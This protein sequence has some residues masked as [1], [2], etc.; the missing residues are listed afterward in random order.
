MCGLLDGGL[1]RHRMD[2]HHRCCADVT[3][4]GSW[5]SI[6]FV[7]FFRI[8]QVSATMMIHFLIL[9]LFTL[10][11]MSFFPLPQKCDIDVVVGYWWRWYHWCRLICRSHCD[12]RIAGKY[13]AS[14]VECANDWRCRLLDSVAQSAIDSTECVKREIERRLQFR[15]EPNRCRMRQ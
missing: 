2:G 9:N 13:D 7:I 3:E 11:W 10:F 8:S 14:Y 15:W 12:R 5:R 4:F 6:V 1:C